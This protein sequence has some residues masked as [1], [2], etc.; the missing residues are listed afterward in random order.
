[1]K[2]TIIVVLVALLFVM[3]F[4]LKISFKPF[5]I[6]A[7]NW[8]IGVAWI[9]FAFGLAFFEHGVQKKAKDKGYKEAV[10]DFRKVIK[11]AQQ[12]IDSTKQPVS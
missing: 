10:D 9:L 11:E 4:N 7:D 2:A 12:K 1:M 8:P 5:K 3:I 6:T